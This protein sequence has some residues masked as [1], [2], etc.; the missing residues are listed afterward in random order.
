M[1]LKTTIFCV[2][3]KNDPLWVVSKSV[4]KGFIASQIDVLCSNLVK[5]GRGE[6]GK[7]MRYLPDK[8]FAS[9]SRSR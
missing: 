6:I 5:F 3:W 8:K 7:V 1:T 9:L 2:F 4:A